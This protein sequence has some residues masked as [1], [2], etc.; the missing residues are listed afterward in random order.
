MVDWQNNS[1]QLINE[2]FFLFFAYYIFLF[3]N[4]V[5]DP[6][7]RYF[8]GTVYLWILAVNTALNCLIILAMIVK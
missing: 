1:V 2:Y 5:P 6:E 8:F 7:T 4:Y 3:T